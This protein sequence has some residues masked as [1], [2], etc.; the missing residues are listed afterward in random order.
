M[1]EHLPH[2]GAIDSLVRARHGDPFSL[3]GPHPVEG[4]VAVRT[5]LPEASRVEVVDATSGAVRGTLA[6]VHGDGLWS[7]LVQGEQ[8]YRLRIA[9]PDPVG[10]EAVREVADPYAFPPLL[11]ELDIYLISEGRHRDLA[12][13]LAPTR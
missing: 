2:P 11:G 4:G 7:G 12:Q 9:S 13:V 10:G 1:S 6:R 8:P 5:F 3:L